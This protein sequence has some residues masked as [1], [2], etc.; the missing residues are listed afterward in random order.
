MKPNEHLN[1]VITVQ[2]QKLQYTA[3]KLPNGKINIGRIHE[4][5]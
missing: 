3:Y 1:R 2:G 4:V 5:K